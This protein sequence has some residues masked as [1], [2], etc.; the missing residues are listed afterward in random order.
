VLQ[1][2][3]E[4]DQSLDKWLQL[5]DQSTL[6]RMR[7]FRSLSFLIVLLCFVGLRLSGVWHCD[8]E[9]AYNGFPAAQPVALALVGLVNQER[10]ALPQ[11]GMPLGLM[12]L[13]G[14]W[15]ITL[16]AGFAPLVWVV[17]VGVGARV[18][19]AA[20]RGPPAWG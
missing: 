7:S 15:V 4:I 1:R 10:L 19:R 16:R 13:L 17:E 2:G 9:L 6:V 14:D 8:G 5:G 11:A 18:W 20:S 12:D 3:C